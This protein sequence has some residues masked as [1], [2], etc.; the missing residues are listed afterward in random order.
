MMGKY[1]LISFS[2]FFLSFVLGAPLSSLCV[3]FRNFIALSISGNWEASL[4]Q[5]AE[6][7]EMGCQQLAML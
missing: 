7:F 1:N 2:F 4:L 6:I 5:K 3:M